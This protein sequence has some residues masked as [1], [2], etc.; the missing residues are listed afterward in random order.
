MER[1]PNLI[2]GV[3]I[4]R[5]QQH[6]EPEQTWAGGVEQTTGNSVSP[7]CAWTHKK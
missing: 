3:L 2:W 5:E 6:N 1:T 4:Q 7:K